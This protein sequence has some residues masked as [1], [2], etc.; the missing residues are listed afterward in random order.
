MTNYIKL[1]Q[2]S[3]PMDDVKLCNLSQGDS[4][5][6]YENLYIKSDRV[7]RLEN[8]TYVATVMRLSNGNLMEMSTNKSV[9]RVVVVAKWYKE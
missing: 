6:Y 3:R 1:E 5:L 8:G 7:G 4:F 2:I 9:Q